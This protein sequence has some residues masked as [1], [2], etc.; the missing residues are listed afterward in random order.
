M[1]YGSDL[2]NWERTIE[3]YLGYLKKMVKDKTQVLPALMAIAKLWVSKIDRRPHATTHYSH[4]SALSL[5]R[6]AMAPIIEMAQ[7]ALCASG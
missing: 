2:A 7:G 3:A 4:Y 5:S 6:P 1:K